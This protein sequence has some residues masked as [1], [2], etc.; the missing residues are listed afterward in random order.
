MTES[1]I[2][3]LQRK[4]DQGTTGGLYVSGFDDGIQTAIEIIRQHTQAQGDVYAAVHEVLH[5]DKY[6]ID[7][8]A[9]A[10][11]A[12][13]NM[14]DA[15]ALK[16]E[17]ASKPAY[18]PS[19]NCP[20]E[21][22]VVEALDNGIYHEAQDTSFDTGFNEAK[23]QALVIA[24]ERKPSRLDADDES[25]FRLDFIKWANDHWLGI[26][27]KEDDNEPYKWASEKTI[28]AYVAWMGACSFYYKRSTEPSLS[29]LLEDMTHEHCHPEITMSMPV[30]GDPVSFEEC[31][32]ALLDKLVKMDVPLEMGE[33]VNILTKAVLDAAGGP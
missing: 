16:D 10:A 33:D 9:K 31:A 7:E 12:A 2:E 30:L 24:G 1:L 17:A 8:V 5:R 13:M 22:S 25:L 26:S 11:I 32:M 23:R 29:S 14:G 28:Y 15:S 19:P 3:K 4:I 27:T 20:S 18:R 6:T 21:I